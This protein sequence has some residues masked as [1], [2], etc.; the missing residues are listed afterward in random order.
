MNRCSTNDSLAV[1]CNPT[2]A[3]G[4]VLE[5]AEEITEWIKA[6]NFI[7]PGKFWYYPLSLQLDI[8]ESYFDWLEEQ[9]FTRKLTA[10]PVIVPIC[11]WLHTQK[12]LSK[13]FRMKKQ[14]NSILSRAELV[15]E[16]I[17]QILD[18]D[19]NN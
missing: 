9:G 17:N 10:A 12:V 18:K 13:E 11:D 8:Y 5:P 7:V 3:F 19:Y 4:I 14:D 1:L 6:F 15:N 2:Y 16:F